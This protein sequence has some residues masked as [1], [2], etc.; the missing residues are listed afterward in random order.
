MALQHGVQG[1]LL[2]MA[3]P[4]EL[5]KAIGTTHAGELWVPRKLLPPVSG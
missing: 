5:V 1:C 3:R 4:T 2:N